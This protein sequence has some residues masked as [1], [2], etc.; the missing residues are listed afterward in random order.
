MCIFYLFLLQYWSI[1][2]IQAISSGIN[3]IYCPYCP[4]QRVLIHFWVLFP[5]VLSFSISIPRVGGGGGGGELPHWF[6]CS[7]TFWSKLPFTR[8]FNASTVASRKPL[9]TKTQ[10]Y[11]S[12]VS[13]A[14]WNS[15]ERKKKD[16]SFDILEEGSGE[17]KTSVLADR[18]AKRD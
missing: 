7:L 8:A 15:E 4:V 9:A 11:S 14:I 1:G 13:S 3:S 2:N 18:A 17:G 10:P 6:K 12:S 16:W 5:V